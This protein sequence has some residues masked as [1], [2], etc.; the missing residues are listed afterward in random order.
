MSSRSERYLANAEKCQQYAD[1]VGTSGTKRLYEEL[2]RQW[3]HLAERAEETDGIE[4]SPTSAGRM[5]PPEPQ[6]T[7]LNTSAINSRP[8][9]LDD[10][11]REIE[12]FKNSL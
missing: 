12:R 1:A 3:L 8:D 6:L 4:S 9:M 11:E 2:A 7:P 5:P 10:V